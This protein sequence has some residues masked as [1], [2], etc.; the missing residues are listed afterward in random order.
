[1]R[2]N[3][4]LVGMMGSG[5][6]VTGKKLALL[7]KKKFVDLDEEIENRSGRTIRDIFEKEGEDYFRD[8]ESRLLK[9]VNPAGQVVATG[10]GVILRAENIAHMRVT[11]KIVYLATSL[12]D[13]WKRLA[14]KKDR[15]L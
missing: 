3:L 10:G 11:G 15:P 2:P 5:K 6:S 14:G 1:M 4:Y 12:E 9:K 13:L 7:L 8:L